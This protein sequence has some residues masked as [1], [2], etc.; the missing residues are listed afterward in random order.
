MD[1]NYNEYT[2][3]AFDNNE[4]I[5]IDKIIES[6]YSKFTPV[7]DST[8]VDEEL[9]LD[10]TTTDI[11]DEITPGGILDPDT[12]LR[13]ENEEDFI[14]AETWELITTFCRAEIKFKD[15]LFKSDRIRKFHES[16]NDV[17]NAQSLAN[18]GKEKIRMI[19]MGEVSEKELEYVEAEIIILFTQ[20]IRLRL[21]KEKIYEKNNPPLNPP[22]K[23]GLVDPYYYE[24]NEKE[25]EETEEELDIPGIIYEPGLG[26]PKMPGV[27]KSV[28]TSDGTVQYYVEEEQGLIR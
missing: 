2:N 11:M 21:F 5:D 18:L 15:K 25:K 27:I 24:M 1:D 8:D 19:E 23:N 26:E 22:L 10:R 9:L 14:D 20:I 7:D 17:F 28:Q 4:I 16:I 13:S 3:L 12:A 6:G